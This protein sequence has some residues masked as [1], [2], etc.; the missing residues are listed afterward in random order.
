MLL[1]IVKCL[2]TIIIWELWR[3]RCGAKYGKERYNIQ[4]S[5]SNI[6]NTI[7]QLIGSQ[8]RN[9]HMDSN[10]GNIVQLMGSNIHPRKMVIVR[11]YR[12]SESFVKWN[13]DGSCKNDRCGSGGVVK[14]KEGHLIFAYSLKLG[15]GS[16]NWAE[17]NALLFGIN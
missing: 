7:S 3:A 4:R 8:F 14:N 15:K 17:A 11:W 16:S 6:T 1:F 12:P 13:T 2:P 10:W 9:V 5:I